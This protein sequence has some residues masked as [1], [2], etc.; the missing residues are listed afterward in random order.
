[1]CTVCVAPS[2]ACAHAHAH[3]A[4]SRACAHAHA[5][6][7]AQRTTQAVSRRANTSSRTCSSSVLV[8]NTV[9][10]SQ[11]DISSASFPPPIKKSLQAFHV[12]IEPIVLEAAVGG[13][14][15]TTTAGERKLIEKLPAFKRRCRRAEMSRAS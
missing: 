14:M 15:G 12:D 10:D 9:L 13:T 5:H 1:M 11:R 4:P 8:E 6:E 7:P 2:H 3:I